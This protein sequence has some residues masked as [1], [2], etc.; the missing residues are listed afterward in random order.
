MLYDQIENIGVIDLANGCPHYGYLPN[1]GNNTVAWLYYLLMTKEGTIRGE[2]PHEDTMSLD[3]FYLTP[4]K[5]IL[6]AHP[7]Q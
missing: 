7:K 5:Q 3:P 6:K 4:F 2:I 1:G